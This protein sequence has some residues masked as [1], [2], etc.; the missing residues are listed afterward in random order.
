MGRGCGDACLGT[1]GEV[2]TA[3]Q[4][5]KIEDAGYIAEKRKKSGYRQIEKVHFF[6]PE[7]AQTSAIFLS[8]RMYLPITEST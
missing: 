1:R 2:K 6:Q 4:G 5:R 8:I 7:V 3:T